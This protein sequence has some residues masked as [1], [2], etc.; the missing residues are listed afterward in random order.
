MKLSVKLICFALPVFALGACGKSPGTGGEP[1]S[2]KP[3]ITFIYAPWESDAGASVEIK[4]K[5]TVQNGNIASAE[6][7]YND[8]SDHAVAMTKTSG[9]DEYAAAFTAPAEKDRTVTYYIEAVTDEEV[10][11]RSEIISMTTVEEGTSV[12]DAAAKLRLNEIG[13]FETSKFI[14]IYNPTGLAAKLGDITLW[15]N[16]ELLYEFAASDELASLSYGVLKAKDANF[17]AS[18]TV[19]G[20]TSTGLSGSKSLSIELR[21]KGNAI[22]AFANTVN[23]GVAQ[24]TIDDWDGDVEKEGANFIRRKGESTG[25]YATDAAATPGKVNG[26]A[27]TQLKH[28]LLAADAVADKPYITNVVINPDK[29]TAGLTPTDNVIR[30]SVYHD[31]HGAAPTVTSGNGS[32]TPVSGVVY[33]VKPSLSGSSAGT[34]AT[35]TMTASNSQGSYAE[36]VSVLV[37]P[38][39]QS[40]GAYGDIRLNEIYTQSSDAIELYNTSDKPVVI[41]GMRIRKNKDRIFTIPGYMV[42]KAKGFAVLGCNGKNYTGDALNLGTVSN[43][44]SGSKSLLIELRKPK[45]EGDETNSVNIDDFVNIAKSVSAPNKDSA[46]DTDGLIEHDFECAGRHPDGSGGWYK[47]NVPT[48]GKT[49][50][51]ATRGSAFTQSYNQ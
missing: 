22:D 4:A 25:W 12:N 21:Y 45:E 49:N 36:S 2:T 42:M 50:S 37:Y 51:T 16:G 18:G 30:F 3:Q 11:A 40:F 20:T 48:I 44:L 6:L 38:A 33:E 8:G 41:A 17:T 35:I 29:P 5:I 15:K 26:T 9:A 13:T 47:L 14:E 34:A 46:W 43:G 39:G 19:L 23:P 7:R 24:M 10:S 1:D 32:V 28:Q 31:V 27:G